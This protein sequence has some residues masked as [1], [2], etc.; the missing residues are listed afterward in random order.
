V[1]R[2]TAERWYNTQCYHN[3]NQYATDCI[4]CLA[5]LI[6]EHAIDLEERWKAGLITVLFEPGPEPS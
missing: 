4:D 3:Y 1:S 6:T 2:S 5:D